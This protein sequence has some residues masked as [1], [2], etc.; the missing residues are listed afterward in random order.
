MYDPKGNVFAVASKAGAPRTMF[1]PDDGMAYWEEQ[2]AR[3]SRR[4]TAGANRERAGRE[5][6]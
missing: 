2:K 5:D 6:S 3:E 1:K 4:Q